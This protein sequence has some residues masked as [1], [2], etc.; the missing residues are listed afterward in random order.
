MLVAAVL[1]LALSVP[2]ALLCAVAAT[3][4]VVAG[5]DFSSFT[6]D[7][8]GRRGPGDDLALG[9]VVALGVLASW[10]LSACVLA[11]LVMRR[12][13]GA[14]IAL[15]VSSAATAVVSLLAIGTLVSVLTLAASIAVIVLLLVGGSPRRTPAGPVSSRPGR[16]RPG[17]AAPRR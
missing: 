14:R 13:H 10:A 17:A 4:M 11:V 15:V 12:H 6:F 2:T 16:P 1:T 8:P 7:D 3:V 9:A 5:D